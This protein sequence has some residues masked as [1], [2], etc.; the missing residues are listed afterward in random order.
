M[1]RFKTVKYKKINT[2]IKKNYNVMRFL[3]QRLKIRCYAYFGNCVVIN[4][5]FDSNELVS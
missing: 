1:S 4:L 3:K 5:V 2:Y